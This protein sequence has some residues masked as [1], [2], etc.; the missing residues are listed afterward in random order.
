MVWTAART[1]TRQS[2]AVHRSSGAIN[3]RRRP[4]VAQV[5]TPEQVVS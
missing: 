2:V 4:A 1:L 3:F 5:I